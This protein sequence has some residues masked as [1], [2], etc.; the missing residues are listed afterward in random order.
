MGVTGSWC[1]RMDGDGGTVARGRGWFKDN[2]E[3]HAGECASLSVKRL[4]S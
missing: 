1:L 2:V 3:P 4:P